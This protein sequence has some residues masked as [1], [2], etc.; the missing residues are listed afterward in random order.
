MFWHKRTDGKGNIFWMKKDIQFANN[1]NALVPLPYYMSGI[2]S[3]TH[4]GLIATSKSKT[5]LVF[6]K[7]SCLR[8][9]QNTCKVISCKTNDQE[10]NTFT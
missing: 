3:F 8:T 1:I 4:L 9:S 7:Q 10:L 5:H 2:T 6:N